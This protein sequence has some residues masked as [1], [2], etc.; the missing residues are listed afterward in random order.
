MVFDVEGTIAPNPVTVTT[1]SISI[2]WKEGEV[3]N[4]ITSPYIGYYLYYRIN[5]TSN[6]TRCCN[7]TFDPNVEW[8]QGTIDELEPDTEYE[9]DISVYRIHQSGQVYEETEKTSQGLRIIIIRTEVCKYGVPISKQRY[10]L[11][12]NKEK[13]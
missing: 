7:V 4:P 11:Y 10:T 12:Y 8:Q 5:G 2:Q 1:D 3:L 13:H 9:I 6:W